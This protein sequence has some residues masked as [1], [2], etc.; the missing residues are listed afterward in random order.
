[1]NNTPISPKVCIDGNVIRQIREANKLTQL[2][3]AKVVGVTT[4]TVSRW[5]NN[6][7]PSIR[8]DNALLLAEALEVDLADILLNGTGESSSADAPVVK[9]FSYKVLLP[10]FIVFALILFVY[11]YFLQ[12]QP[13]TYEFSAIRVLPTFA[14]SDGTLPVRVRLSAS[15]DIKG[16]ILR[17]HFPQGWKLLQASPPPSSLDNVEGM[18]RWILKP[19]ERPPVISYLMQVPVDLSVSQDYEFTG[20]VIINPRGSGVTYAVS[21]DKQVH[22]GAFHWADD[23]GDLVIDDSETLAAS[24]SIDEMEKL[25]LSWEI[26]E[27]IW[28]AGKYRWDAEQKIFQPVRGSATQQ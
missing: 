23:N 17:E 15:G 16:M 1:M 14:V 21:G 12:S 7:Y 26:I 22:A 9:K 18:V 24:D 20:E 8:R 2:Y 13:A 10:I 28:D 6:R 4:D 25:H 5:E 3:V 27:K 11:F 19:D